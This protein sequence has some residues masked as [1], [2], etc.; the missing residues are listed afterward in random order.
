MD[1]YVHESVQRQGVGSRLFH[2]MLEVSCWEAM[3]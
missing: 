3:H 1:F 2:L